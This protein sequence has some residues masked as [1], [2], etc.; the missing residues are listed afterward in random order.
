[1]EFNIL[2]GKNLAKFEGSSYVGALFFDLSSNTIYFGADKGDGT[3]NP[4]AMDQT[5]IQHLQTINATTGRYE[6]SYA[7]KSS[8]DDTIV[9]ILDASIPSLDD[10]TWEGKDAKSE[11]YKLGTGNT[12]L[13]NSVDKL[14]LDK[15]A[16]ALGIETEYYKKSIDVDGAT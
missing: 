6:N 16:E 15:I 8:A 11:Y 5:A 7:F 3:V 2:K 4:I 1:M 13:M 9:T 12:G 14:V 10:T